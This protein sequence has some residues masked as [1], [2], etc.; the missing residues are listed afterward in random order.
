[1]NFNLAQKLFKSGEF[2]R[3]CN[4]TKDTLFHYDDIDLLKP[5]KIANNGYRYYSLNQVF[6][7]DMISMFKEVGMSLDEIKNYI[8]H[9]GAENFIAMLK[10][11]DKKMYEEIERLKRLRKLLKNTINITQDSFKVEENKIEFVD[12]E[13]QYF[14]VT[15]G[16]KDSDEK[17]MFEAMLY[18]IDYCKKHN[19][20]YSF[21]FGEIIGNDSIKENTFKTLH[22]STKIDKKINN[23]HLLIKPAGRYA[24]KYIRNSYDNLRNEY[25]I[26][27]RE[28][29]DKNYKLI[30]HLYEEDM[31]N[32]LSETDFNNYLMKIEIRVER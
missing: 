21:G 5:A 4:T 1:M 18:H 10:E 8:K 29:L 14:I 12:E 9:R 22:Y 27:C 23:K 3:L 32:H 7:F 17:A 13:E 20:D 26:F 15:N 11:K 25:R 28:L 19:F 16:E 2:A 30:G 24:V 31:L 6:I